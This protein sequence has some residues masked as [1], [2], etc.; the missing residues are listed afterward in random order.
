MLEKDGQI[1]LEELRNF[2]RRK[3]GNSGSLLYFFHTYLSLLLSGYLTITWMNVLSKTSS[4]E[5]VM[6]VG[7]GGLNLFGVIVLG[8]MLK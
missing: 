8:T 4:S 2:S 1:G 6:V 3:D 7:L 5:R